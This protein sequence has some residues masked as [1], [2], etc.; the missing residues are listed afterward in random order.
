MR[1]LDQETWMVELRCCRDVGP[2]PRDSHGSVPH[3]LTKNLTSDRRCLTL[4]P[5][6]PAMQIGR[7]LR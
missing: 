1:Q 6:N 4:N 5:T 2:A 3:C 7:L